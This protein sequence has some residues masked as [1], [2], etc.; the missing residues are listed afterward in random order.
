[1]A[2]VTHAT[3]ALWNTTAGTATNKNVTATPA[4]NDLIVVIAAS[5]GLTG[6]TTAVTDN[7]SDGLGTYTQAD[8]DRTGFST[9]GV[10][11]LWVRNALVGSATSTVFTAAQ[12]GSSGGGLDV[13]RISGM[14][15]TG[16][17]A[18]RQSAGQ[19]SGTS[20]TTP[21]P[22]LGSAALTGNPMI[23]AVANGTSAATL[24]PRT[25]WTEATDLGYSTPTTGLETM[26]RSSGETGTT[27]TWGST[28]GSTFASVAAE[29]DTSVPETSPQ[30]EASGFG[31]FTGVG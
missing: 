11:T 15:L 14:T 22:V 13:F 8:A 31:T 4:A 12:N 16:A 2:T 1:M 20:G 23:G 30:L 24:T 19:S 5:S 6:G 27:M 25:S 17:S 7:N 18:V 9:T 26:F 10:L 28:S 3:T 29:F 21:A